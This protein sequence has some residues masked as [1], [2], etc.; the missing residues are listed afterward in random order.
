MTRPFDRAG[1]PVDAEGKTQVIDLRDLVTLD[2]DPERQASLRKLLV[3][4]EDR[5]ARDRE[6]LEKTAR[7]VREGK[8]RLERLD[9]INAT[10]R[11]PGGPGLA[12]VMALTQQLFENFHRRLLK[13]YPYAVK[14]QGQTVGVC[15]TLEEARL[16]AQHFADA[17]P[18][19]I[20]TVVDGKRDR[21]EAVHPGHPA[22]RSSTE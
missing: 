20:V 7:L 15:V 8:E 13:E 9:R 18:Q 17:N 16:R 5:L 2:V 14:L 21:T 6:R 11:P 19:A 4:E 1:E 10:H 3:E 22:S 12:G